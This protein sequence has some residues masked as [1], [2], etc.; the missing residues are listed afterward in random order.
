[1][2]EASSIKA[3]V[4]V[5]GKSSSKLQI[6]LTLEI[7]TNWIKIQGFDEYTTQG[8]IELAQRYP[9]QALPSFRKNFN[10]MIERVRNKRKLELR[11]KSQLKKE[12]NNHEE[13]NNEE[14]NN[15]YGKKDGIQNT[16]N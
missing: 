12:E 1:M 8:L 9:T 11:G 10:V 5:P 2:S 15:E 16:E 13:K 6:Q 7:I 3:S 4:N 14:K